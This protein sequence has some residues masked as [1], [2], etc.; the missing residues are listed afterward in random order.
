[1]KPSGPLE[2]YVGSS[3]K[4]LLNISV[5]VPEDVCIEKSFSVFLDIGRR[6]DQERDSC[7]TEGRGHA[8][9]PAGGG[10]AFVC[11]P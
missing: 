7:Y 6:G 11:G 10:R 3:I 5:Q 4:Y 2:G 8:R 9:C 1:M